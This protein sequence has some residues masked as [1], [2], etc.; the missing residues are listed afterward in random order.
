MEDNFQSTQPLLDLMSWLIFCNPV[1]LEFSFGLE[2][3][4]LPH[5][6]ASML[7]TSLRENPRLF[8]RKRTSDSTAPFLFSCLITLPARQHRN[9]GAQQI[10]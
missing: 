5:N 8:S 3:I 2:G 7:P 9:L 6:L 1:P 4:Q 10:A